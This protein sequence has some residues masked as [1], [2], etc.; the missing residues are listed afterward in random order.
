[1]PW[2]AGF[3]DVTLWS[4]PDPATFSSRRELETFL[5]S[6]VLFEALDELPAKR[7]REVVSALADRL[8]VLS[9]DYVRLNALARRR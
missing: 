5:D 2:A 3:D 4:H 6:V 1:M 7:R 8:G 9:L